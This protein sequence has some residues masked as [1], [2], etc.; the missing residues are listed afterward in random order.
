MFGSRFLH[1]PA[2]SGCARKQGWS[3]V[4]HP[5]S[6]SPLIL[7]ALPPS[8]PAQLSSRLSRFRR[9]RTPLLCLTNCRFLLTG[10]SCWSR[11][12]IRSPPA[13]AIM[14]SSGCSRPPADWKMFSLPFYS[15]SSF[16]P[17]FRDPGTKCLP[18]FLLSAPRG[19]HC[20]RSS[21]CQFSQRRF[22]DR[23]YLIAA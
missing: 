15:A 16:C 8:S 19:L 1:S 20:H 18:S 9:S 10:P 17:G 23:H 12:S 14:A 21:C 22:V 3:S 13:T 2:R 4:M 6:S 5:S 11:P 7:A